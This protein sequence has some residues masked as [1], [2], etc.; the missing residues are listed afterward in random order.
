MNNELHQNHEHY[1]NGKSKIFQ[2]HLKKINSFVLFNKFF[3]SNLFVSMYD[4]YCNNFLESVLWWLSLHMH[5]FSFC[6]C[7]N[8]GAP[9]LYLHV[10]VW[11]LTF[12]REPKRNVNIRVSARTLSIVNRAT[13]L[14]PKQC[15]VLFIFVCFILWQ[16][17]QGLF[18][19]VA[20]L[21]SFYNV[22]CLS[23]VQFS[24]LL[25][26]LC[27]LKL[28]ICGARRTLSKIVLVE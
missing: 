21:G 9:S 25:S 8:E 16:S 20:V 5:F 26:Y 3:T 1:G 6:F 23:F 27:S 12:V 2:I 11:C 15:S 7:H 18:Q 19:A 17:N 10:C 22:N 4:L 14:K 13:I 28:Y 24:K